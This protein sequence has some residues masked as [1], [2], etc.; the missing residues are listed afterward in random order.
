[1]KVLREPLLH[2]LF[3]GAALFAVYGWLGGN[4]QDNEQ[5]SSR[6]VHI[7]A[8]DVQWLTE[9]WKRQWNREPTLEEARGLVADY[10][11]EEILSRESRAMKLD[12][13]DIVVRRR[14]AQKLSFLIEDTVH[15]AEPTEDDLRNIYNANPQRFDPGARI[16]FNQ[17]YFNPE[18]R[19]DAL[20]DAK[21]VLTGLPANGNGVDTAEIGDRLLTGSDFRGA[22]EQ[23]VSAAFGP[24]FTKKIFSL[25]SGSWSGPLRSGYG[26][27]LIYVE[28]VQNAKASDLADIRPKLVAEW[29]RVQED[30]ANQKF[31][32]TLRKKY[33]VIPDESVKALVDAQ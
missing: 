4:K 25:K 29:R 13:N 24:E 23:A 6:T 14:L 2:F 22:D 16:S 7:R 26:F 33:E 20:G 1:M 11:K 27:H 8:A 5:E 9:I 19:A 15:L 30:I 32:A 28:G 17:I 10:L 18:R 21:Q 31:M 12:E 3:A